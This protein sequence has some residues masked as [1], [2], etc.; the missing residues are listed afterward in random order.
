VDLQLELD[1]ALPPV[2]ADPQ[3]LQEVFMN[4]L[5]NAFDAAEEGGRVAVRTGSDGTTAVRVSVTDDGV[6]IAEANLPHIF[7]PFF[8]TK[9]PGKGTGLGLSVAQ[10]IVEAYRGTIGVESRPGAGSTFT[11]RLPMREQQA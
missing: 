10:G 4:L 6:G 8:T 9:D 7:E 5:L 2:V 3:L 1:P 11:V